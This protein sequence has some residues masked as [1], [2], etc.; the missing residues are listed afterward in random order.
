MLAETNPLD[1]NGQE[2]PSENEKF[3]SEF[4]CQTFQTKKGKNMIKKYTKANTNVNRIIFNKQLI[5]F[6][7]SLIFFN[8]FLSFVP[9]SKFI[10]FFF[11]KKH[12]SVLFS[13]FVC[14]LYPSE[15]HIPPSWFSFNVF[16]LDVSNRV[17]NKIKFVSMFTKLNCRF[18]CFKNLL[19]HP[20]IFYFFF[21]WGHHCIGSVR[22]LSFSRF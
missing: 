11:L 1:G 7:L 21:F 5:R 19:N 8:V 22:F 6:H 3:E 13:P 9:L 2:W 14:L 18:S 4:V 16:C 12:L 10:C 17:F 15:E 20:K